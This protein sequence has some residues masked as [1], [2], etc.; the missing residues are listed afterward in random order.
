MISLVRKCV[1]EMNAYVPGEQ[2]SDPAV[3]KL[4]T[5]ENP[6]PPSPA[7][8]RALKGIAPDMLRRYPDPDCKDLRAA[9][10]KLH[11][12]KAEQVF[13]GNGSD[14]IL[15]LASRAFV[16][17]DGLLAYFDPSYSLYPV[18][19]RIRDVK[20]FAVGLNNDFSWP[21]RPW[22][23]PAKTGL[24]YMTNPNAPTGMLYPK[25]D[26]LSFCRKFRRVVII[27]EAY[28]DFA[29]ENDMD[30]ALKLKN[31][32]V[33][34]TLSKAYSLA[35]LRVG[36]A[37]GPKELIAALFKVKDSYNVDRAA[38][39]LA[40][41]A[42]NDQAHMRANA[43]RVKATRERLA[44][45]LR[46]MDFEAPPSETNFIWAR[47]GRLT[48]KSLFLKLR[49]KN[50]LVRYFGAGLTREYLRIS[51]GTDDQINRLLKTISEITD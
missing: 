33:L 28:A 29:R 4:N 17:D 47:P 45:A 31:T 36:Y 49:R 24:F 19:A 1:K 2:P 6:Y 7:V 22:R 39:C 26:V 30:L 27:D 10:A 51:I 34:R 16:E 13:V 41:A 43:R 32:L 18:L 8:M 46:N 50:I 38:Q 44:N 15:A 21:A 35:G 20:T 12:C 9:I 48:A 25:K 37:V 3:V 5:N 40:L 42:I 11:G 14:E 23:L